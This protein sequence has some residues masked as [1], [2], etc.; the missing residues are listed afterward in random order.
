[1]KEQKAMV[2][3]LNSIDKLIEKEKQYVEKLKL[4]KKGLMQ[5]LLTGKVKV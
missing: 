5:D 4:K 2:E 1:L 3:R